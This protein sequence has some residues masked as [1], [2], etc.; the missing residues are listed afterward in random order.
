MTIQSSQVASKTIQDIESKLNEKLETLFKSFEK[1]VAIAS[2]SISSLKAEF[3]EGMKIM[4][5]RLTKV[6]TNQ[7]SIE[8]RL[9][10]LEDCCK[11]QQPEEEEEEEKKR[12]QR[13]K[14]NR[15]TKELDN[16]EVSMHGR[17][18]ILEK[19]R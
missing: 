3:V 11:V 13:R 7:S 1:K 2:S 9:N 14:N 10:K 12:E 17:K 15:F 8:K 18:D 4:S 16:E 6:E 5:E 19:Y